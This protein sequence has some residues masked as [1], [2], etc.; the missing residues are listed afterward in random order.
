MATKNRIRELR[1]ERGISQKELAEYLGV[2]QNTLSTWETGRYEPDNEML[3]R[4]SQYF[5]V[6][7]DYLVGAIPVDIPTPEI[8]LL[9]ILRLNRFVEQL[10]AEQGEKLTMI[11]QSMVANGK[12]WLPET[13]SSQRTAQ[14]SDADAELVAAYHAAPES[15]RTGI[16]ALLQPYQEQE[17][18]AASSAG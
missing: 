5:N 10:S 3:Q 4:I 7:I 9:G 1:T 18:S 14:I 11:A 2:R 6:S 13:G 17:A 15:V 8:G 12:A 16:D